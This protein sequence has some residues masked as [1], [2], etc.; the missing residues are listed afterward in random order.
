MRKAQS[1]Q[2]QLLTEKFRN[3]LIFPGKRLQIACNYDESVVD[4]QRTN[5]IFTLTNLLDFLIFFEQSTFLLP[6]ITLLYHN[7]NTEE[8]SS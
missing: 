6:F 2:R 7:L 5:I 3:S 8:L 1:A 4:V